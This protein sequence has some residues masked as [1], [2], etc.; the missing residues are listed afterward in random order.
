MHVY[1]HV[2][3]HVCMY[4]T[5][6]PVA[7]AGIKLVVWPKTTLSE[8]HL[9]LPSRLWDHRC[10]PLSLVHAMME[11]KARDSLVLGQLS[12]VASSCGLLTYHLR[13]AI[14]G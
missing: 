12:C 7:Q 10:A 8:L 13:F 1:I 5:E 3:M 6:S 9:P 2:C 4:E 14:F 11:I